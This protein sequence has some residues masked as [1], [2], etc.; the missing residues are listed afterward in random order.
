VETRKAFVILW[1]R[2]AGGALAMP[3]R[4]KVRARAPRRPRA[5]HGGSAEAPDPKAWAASRA[6]IISRDERISIT[7][8]RNV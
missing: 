8:Y 5:L 4:R 7:V 3:G 6:T 1:D 2:E